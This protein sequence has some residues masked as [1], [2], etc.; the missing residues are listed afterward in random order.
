MTSCPSPW[1]KPVLLAP[2]VN[3]TMVD[4]AWGIWN[5]CHPLPQLISGGELSFLA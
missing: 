1:F 5:K 4:P 3:G 2:V